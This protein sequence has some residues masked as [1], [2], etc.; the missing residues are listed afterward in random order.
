MA[1]EASDSLGIGISAKLNAGGL[2][3]TRGGLV[4]ARIVD[5]DEAKFK[6]NAIQLVGKTGKIEGEGKIKI[7]CMFNPHE[8]TLTKTNNF[9]EIESPQSGDS[10]KAEFVKASPQTLNLNLVFDTYESKQDLAVTMNQL[11]KLMS[12]NWKEGNEKSDRKS[13]P[14]VAFIWGNFYFV[15]YITQMT[16]KFTLF[17]REGIP[18]RAEVTINFTQYV[19][20]NDYPG[21]NPT[22]GDGPIDRVWQ[23][24]GGDR[25]DTIAHAVYG[26]ATKW[27]LIADYNQLQD[28]TQLQ[29]GQQLLIPFESKV[30]ST[31]DAKH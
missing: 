14:L 30:S 19:D 28:A 24:T 3:N 15:A 17:T 8:Y 4:R 27:R 13:P 1:G 5:V 21:Q 29:A 10:P 9:K 20:I 22:S 31:N 7:P 26:N 6:D 16:Q 2:P 12:T 25:I 18:V 11:W 23:V